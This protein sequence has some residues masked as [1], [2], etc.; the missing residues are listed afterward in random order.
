MNTY[1]DDLA[2]LI[3]TLDLQD[4]VLIGHSTGCGKSPATSAATAPPG[5][6]RPCWWARCR[7]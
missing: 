6:P 1:A 4:A 3:E 5:L 2:T 7:R